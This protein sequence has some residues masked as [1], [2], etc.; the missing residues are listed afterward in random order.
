MA[1]TLNQTEAARRE[2]RPGAKAFAEALALAD[3]ECIDR[4]Q[5]IGTLAREDAGRVFV[6]YV[7]LKIIKRTGVAYRWVPVVGAAMEA[8]TIQ[9]CAAAMRAKLAG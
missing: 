1:R 8:R 6:E 3:S 9:G 4:L 5:Q 2:I 7:R